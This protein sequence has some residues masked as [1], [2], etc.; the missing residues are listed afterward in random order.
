MGVVSRGFGYVRALK[1]QGVE[2]RIHAAGE[3]KAGMDPYLPVKSKELARQ[4]RLLKELHGNFIA[5]VKQ[6]R[7]RAALFRALSPRAISPDLVRP[8]PWPRP[9]SVV[10]S[11]DRGSA[12]AQG[13]GERLKP[14]VAARL[15][16]RTAVAA[17]PL[18][19]CLPAALT[20]P[21]R[22]TL[23]KLEAQGA[24]L[25]DGTVYSGAAGVEVGLCDATGE[26][27]TDMARRYGRHV[28]LTHMQVDEPIDYSR[29]LRWLL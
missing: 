16:H 13:R 23:R 20:G 21:S 19:S 3:S 6:A 26:M 18:S 28:Q 11:C 9:I 10:T 2:R 15:Y 27:A 12:C 4:R 17:A 24:G 14:E 7:R 8:R 25:F 1:R 22:R 5:A 29:L